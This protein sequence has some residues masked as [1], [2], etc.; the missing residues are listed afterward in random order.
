MMGQVCFSAYF[1]YCFMWIVGSL[2][3][4]GRGCPSPYSSNGFEKLS[5]NVFLF[6][7]PTY[8]V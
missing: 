5:Q 1:Y 4:E 3:G 7:S 8:L 6:H 2:G